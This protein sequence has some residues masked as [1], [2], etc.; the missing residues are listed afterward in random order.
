MP[1]TD[2]AYYFAVFILR[3]GCDKERLTPD[4]LFFPHN[5]GQISTE[6]IVLKAKEIMQ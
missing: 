2:Q 3:F 6:G 4:I 5:G 1:L